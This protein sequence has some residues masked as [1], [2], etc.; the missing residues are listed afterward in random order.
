[1]VRPDDHWS[2][3]KPASSKRRTV[4]IFGFFRDVHSSSLEFMTIFCIFPHEFIWKPHRLNIA[5]ATDMLQGKVAVITGASSGIG[6]A[7]AQRL[8]REGVNMILGARRKERLD[9]VASAAR[10]ASG[11]SADVLAAPCDITERAE[12][13]H[14][15]ETAM[16]EFGRLDILVNNAGRGHFASVEETTDETIRSMFAVNVFPLWYTTR[17][18]VRQ[19]R[20]QG[21]GHIINVASIAGK[22]GFPF[23]SAYVAAKHAVVGFT[24]ALRLE[25]AETGIHASVVIPAGVLT[26][27][28]SVT[29]GAP[30]LPM[31]SASGP[32]IKKIAEERGVSLPPIE[33]VQPAEAIA[34]KIVSCLYHPVAEV[35]TH[36]GSHEFVVL[37]AQDREQA[38]RHQIPVVLGERTMYERYRPRT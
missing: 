11:S 25:L 22:I 35:Y 24:H 7:L 27:W 14:L 23:N 30:M 13:E 15:V 12:A 5:E 31:F 6:A 20:K 8:G 33:G 17:P 38:E 21:N 2:A 26:E 28:A 3:Q 32:L 4:S 9:Q 18:A 29:E 10:A 34:D 36:R 16:K 1:M 37:S 19:M